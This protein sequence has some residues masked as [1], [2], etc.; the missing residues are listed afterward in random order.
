MANQHTIAEILNA[1]GKRSQA[2]KDRIGDGTKLPYDEVLTLIIGFAPGVAAAKSTAYARAFADGERRPFVLAKLAKMRPDTGRGIFHSLVIHYY[3]KDEPV[4][5]AGKAD[6]AIARKE[7]RLKALSTAFRS[8]YKEGDYRD[9]FAADDRLAKLLGD[10]DLPKQVIEHRHI[11]QGRFKGD[12]QLIDAE[13][14][15]LDERV[16]ELAEAEH[17]ARLPAQATLNPDSSLPP[18]PDTGSTLEDD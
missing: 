17:T 9:M 4:T 14:I 15:E 16:V 13:I 18:D 6:A 8:L 2:D 12:M 3:S 1:S 10:I 11:F 5:K 7:E